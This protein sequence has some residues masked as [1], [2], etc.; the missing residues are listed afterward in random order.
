MKGYHMKWLP[1]AIILICLFYQ[2][3]INDHS[4][5]ASLFVISGILAFYFLMPIVK[6]KLFLMIGIIILLHLLIFLVD[7]SIGLSIYLLLFYFLMECSKYV[8]HKE[9]IITILVISIVDIM[10]GIVYLAYPFSVWI[11]MIFLFGV[12]FIRWNEMEGDYYQLKEVYESLL[13]DFRIQKRQSLQNERGARLEE[14][15]MIAREMHD[16]VGHKLTALLMQTEQY[17]LKEKHPHYLIIKQ[18]AAECLEETRKAVRLLQSDEISGIESVI[19]L[20][21]KLESESNIHIHF[22]I[23]QGML[24]LPISNQQSAVLYRSIQE[25]ITNAMKYGSSREISITLGVSPIGYLTFEL[26]NNYVHTHPIHYG[27]G[28][29]NMKKRVEEVRGKL[30]IFQIEGQF[31]LQGSIPVGRGNN[32]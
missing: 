24:H 30:D 18:M 19:S 26:K 13:N 2:S 17:W 21:K 25:G 14:R 4:L 10:L 23:K 16:S 12:L 32:D 31:I 3:A 6:K 8:F 11:S 5:V 1:L 28:L 7:H 9:W 22:T 20:I 27:F 29:E 15:N